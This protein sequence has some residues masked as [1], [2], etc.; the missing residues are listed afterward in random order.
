MCAHSVCVLT[1]ERADGFK[2]VAVDPG[3]IVSFQQ[4]RAQISLKNAGHCALRDVLPVHFDSSVPGSIRGDCA[5]F[6]RAVFGEDINE[7]LLDRTGLAWHLPVIVHA[8]K[9]RA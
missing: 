1:K 6:Q 9:F 2:L 4:L 7:N 5:Y 3:N 8:S